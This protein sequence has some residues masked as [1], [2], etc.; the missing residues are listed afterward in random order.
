MNQDKYTFCFDD[1]SL[2]DNEL[3][4]TY[5][6]EDK[7]GA[8]LAEFTERYR[9]PDFL[10]PDLK[11]PT[12]IYILQILHLII[13]ISYYKSLL[14][15]IEQP[16]QLTPSEADYLNEV[17]DNGLGELLFVN[18]L[19]LYLQPFNATAGQDRQ[20]VRLVDHKGALLGVGGGKDSAVAAEI[21]KHVKL[22][23]VTLDVATRD[24]HGQAGAVMD[25]I[26]LEQIRLER[27]I[28][29]GIV[30]FTDKNQG[31][32]GHIPLSVILA[33]LGTLVAY[34]TGKQYIMMANEA[35]AS[36]GNVQ[37][38]GREVNH[39]WAKSF[40]AEQL[41]QDFIHQHISPDLWYFSPI[42]PYGSLAVMELFAQLCQAYYNDFTSC[43]LV[44]RINPA[45]R[46]NGRWCT[47][48]AKCLST[49]L[50]L[51]SKLDTMCLIG[52]FGRDLSA[53]NSLRPTLEALL[54][55]S[56]HK[57]LDCVG[58]IEELR[59]VSR[60]VIDRGENRPLFDGIKSEDIP[61]PSIKDLINDRSPASLPPE[62]AKDIEH[63]V[64]KTIA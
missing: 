36:S 7:D 40:E 44:L 23:T 33:W 29:T 21:A 57:P 39:Q 46:P 14:G 2:A 32:H 52:I 22:S 11:D 18:K 16:Y 50:L 41:T 24:N 62:L 10:K 51:S 28:D 26:G 3:A 35:A 43:N 37:W 60:A 15:R 47:H 63:F 58:T 4:F 19:R 49:W 8:H 1:F 5:H 64:N 54:G 56:G 31:Y 45:E 48:C 17:Y 53:D 59:A 12:T 27:Y 30:E 34:T 25:I 20:P 6:Y 55:L 42:R 61:G 13:G 9:L 38:N